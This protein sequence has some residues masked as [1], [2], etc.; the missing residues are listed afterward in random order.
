MTMITF[1]KRTLWEK[2]L[3]LVPSYKRKQDKELE[4]AIKILMENPAMPC[5][6]GDTI[7]PD[8]YGTSLPFLKGWPW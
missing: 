5:I 7:I 1:R 3:R 2:L 4:D 6:I 8:G